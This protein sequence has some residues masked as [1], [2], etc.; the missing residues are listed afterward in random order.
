MI[1]RTNAQPG[2]CLFNRLTDQRIER[3]SDRNP[4]PSARLGP[5]CKFELL[6]FDRLASII[7]PTTKRYLKVGHFKFGRMDVPGFRSDGAYICWLVY[8]VNK[9]RLVRLT[10]LKQQAWSPRPS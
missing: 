9:H 4:G 5:I 6:K 2:C 8:R 7:C 1:E 3:S 10:V